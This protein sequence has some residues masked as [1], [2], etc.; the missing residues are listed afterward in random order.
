[1]LTKEL[2]RERF[3]ISDYA[4]RDPDRSEIGFFRVCEELMVNGPIVATYKFL[5]GEGSSSCIKRKGKVKV[6]RRP[7]KGSGK[8]GEMEEV[9]LRHAVVVTGFRRV[10]GENSLIILN[11]RGRKWG[12]NGMALLYYN[13]VE[14]VGIPL[15]HKSQMCTWPEKEETSQ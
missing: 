15:V 1:M 8:D 6:V 5:E 13:Q 14:S 3:T 10:E 12:N 11:S 2:I 4:V 9:E 7:V